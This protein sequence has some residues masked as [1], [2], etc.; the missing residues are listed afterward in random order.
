MDHRA[1]F[2]H[3]HPGFFDRDY[4][5]ALPENETYAEMILPLKGFSPDQ[6]EIPV[7]EGVAFGPYE[8]SLTAL[9]EAVRQVEEAW[10]P[11]YQKGGRVYC[12]MDGGKIASFCLIEDMGTFEGLRIGGPGCVGTVP[13]CRRKGIGLKMVQNVTAILKRESYDLSCIHYTGVAPWYGK[14]GYETV[15]RWNRNGFLNEKTGLYK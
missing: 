9:L 14:L 7:P 11:I 6:R 1:L 12:A 10:A 13:A 5:K 4:I 2:H 3:L 15:L 8:G